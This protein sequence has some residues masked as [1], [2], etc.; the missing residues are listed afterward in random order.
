M[1]RLLTLGGL[2]LV[3][4]GVPVTGAASQRSRLALLAVLAAA[5]PAGVARDKLLALLWPE[6]DDER[7]RHALKQGVYAL[8][9][10]LGN[11]NAIA[12]TATLSLDASVVASDM[13]EFDDAI[14]RGEDA[15][16][17]AMYAGPFLDGVFIKA[18]PE[19]DHWAATERSRL[20]RDH[21]DA[22][23]RLAR[24]AEA[25]GDA[26]TAVQWW[27]RGAAAEPVSGRVALSLMRALA[28][29]GD[30]SAAI[31]HARVHDAM[32]RGELDSPADDAVL[33][34]A[35][36]LR[37]GAYVP[38]ARA[39]RSTP[40]STPAVPI[41]TSPEA[42][43]AA[44]AAP[45][46]FTPSGI[47]TAPAAVPPL[48][49][50]RWRQRAFAALGVVLG[51][52]LAASLVP[53]ARSR[54]G[55]MV[56]GAQTARSGRRIVVATFDNRTGDRSLDPLGEL[57]SD[58]LARTLLEAEF[59]VVD[60][61]TSATLTRMIARITPAGTAHDH[62][63]ALAAQTGAATVITGSYYRQ[64]DSLQFEANILDPVR[65]V[66]LHAVG[67]LRGPTPAATSL[68]GVLA[69]RVTAAM[70]VSADSTVGARTASVVEPPSVEAFEHVSRAWEMFFARP[71]D[72]A[73]VFAEL[74][75]ASA[76]DT[77]YTAPLLMRA[78]VLDVK[79]QWP[80]LAD[81]VK[82]LE[83]RRARMGRIEREILAL[84]ESDLRGDLL[85][86]L[87]ASRELV[88]LSPGSADM[89]LLLS[90]SASYLNRATEALA[91]SNGAN[92]DRGINLVSPMYWA[93]RAVSEHAL[94]RY[95]D[96]LA[97]ATQESRRFPAS[98]Y[99]ARTFVRAYAARGDMRAL[100]ALLAQAG[101]SAPI[102]RMDARDLALRAARELHVHGYDR[103]AATL[104]A[105]VAMIRPGTTASRDELKLHALALYESG[106]FSGARAAYTAL[107]P[108]STGDLEVVGRLGAIAA[109]MGDS[110][111][112]RRID[113]QL[114]QW[115][116]MYALGQPTYWRAHL[117]ALAGRG[118]D[119]VS[120]L[121]VAIG[122][123]YRPTELGTVRLH[124]EGDFASLWKDPAFRELVRPR[125]G[126]AIIP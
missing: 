106:N 104:F 4:D 92:P 6:S 59:E 27:R 50:S 16:A 44:A 101:M 100:Q 121:R 49:G 55:L 31:Q 37:R 40:I 1:L 114:A 103:D 125:D 76:V 108:T 56:P 107:P 3:D 95:D 61:R 99:A 70:A 39:P 88:R 48:A 2:S 54:I 117:A 21:L 86:R 51:V 102:P 60:S 82:Q 81:M 30:V 15:A 119:A 33:A 28:D 58:W 90:V 96:E 32:V 78:Y 66:I 120:L 73:A 87:R 80:A 36:E 68:V 22:I 64:G 79:E 89:A 24:A 105:R 29:A 5:G 13:R 11:E 47:G 25:A 7:A 23:G 45:E 112:V 118:S 42:E 17:I 8:R 71:S 123:G 109:R 38:T 113:L 72:T 97:S 43:Q 53:G 74:A 52:G 35:E 46:S 75:R 124:E 115:S 12:G 83:P 14:A 65:G 26:P 77:A 84:F 126:P 111:A 122:Q 34:F 94:G 63:A 85:G 91:A 20:E 69:K 67:P 116:A 93:W 62:A 18:A 41:V 10:D 98:P 9:R 110:A 57:A 19:F